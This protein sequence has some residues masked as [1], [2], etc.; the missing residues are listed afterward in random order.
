ML[1]RTFLLSAK[2]RA[3]TGAF[4]SARGAA[5][6]CCEGVWR[7]VAEARWRPLLAAGADSPAHTPRSAHAQAS[8]KSETSPA[9]P[10]HPSHPPHPPPPPPGKRFSTLLDS[11]ASKPANKFYHASALVL[12]GLTPVAFIM[13]SWVNMPVDLALGVLFPLHSHIALNYVISDYVP[14]AVR[15]AARVGLFGATLV[16]LVGILKLN[17]EGPGLTQTLTALWKGKK[18]ARKASA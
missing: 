18:A 3:A 14:K 17:I 13:P 2:A 10:P 16:T 4:L 11:D 9:P 6:F 12:A 5:R 15:S 7:R 8:D 1:G